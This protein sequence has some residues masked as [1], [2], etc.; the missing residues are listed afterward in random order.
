MG[1]QAKRGNCLGRWEAGRTSRTPLHI[2]APVG[3]SAMN[4]LCVREEKGR[5]EGELC[6]HGETGGQQE[7]GRH[8]RCGSCRNPSNELFVCRGREEA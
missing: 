3:S 7:H 8:R 6:L 5:E 1:R 2:V 4:R